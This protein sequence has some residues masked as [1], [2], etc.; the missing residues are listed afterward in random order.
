[1]PPV[2]ESLSGMHGFCGYDLGS[3]IARLNQ[4]AGVSSQVATDCPFCVGMGSRSGKVTLHTMLLPE[5]G[6][7]EK[8]STLGSSCPIYQ[9]LS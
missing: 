1:M 8:N 3:H 7:D 5:F 2:F 4:I 9:P 6:S